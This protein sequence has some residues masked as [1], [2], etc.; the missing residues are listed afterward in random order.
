MSLTNHGYLG[1]AVIVNKS[2]GTVCP[3][4]REQR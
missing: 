2:S 1:Y 3:P 4:M